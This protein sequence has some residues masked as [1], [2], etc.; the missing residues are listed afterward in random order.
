MLRKIN[1][2]I[3]NLRQETDIHQADNEHNEAQ[4]IL[5]MQSYAEASVVII[6]I[7]RRELV[8]KYVLKNLCK[9]CHAQLYT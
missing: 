3:R 1:F 9:K 4:N 8:E 5:L 6:K 2:S 7:D